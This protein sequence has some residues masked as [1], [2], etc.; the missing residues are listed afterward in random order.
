MII[1]ARRGF[2]YSLNKQI[3]RMEPH[4]DESLPYIWR[5]DYRNQ[6]AFPEKVLEITHQQAREY[7][8]R[9][10]AKTSSV[11]RHRWRGRVRLTGR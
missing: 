7:F 2:A 1:T 8:G 10:V 9:A 5:K 4:M 11:G 6:A 3:E